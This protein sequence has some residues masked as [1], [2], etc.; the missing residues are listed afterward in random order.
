MRDKSEPVRDALWRVFRV[1]RDKEELCFALAN[2]NIQPAAHELAI[3]RI[4]P[5]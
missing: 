2:Q 3:E 1:V 4:E 5:L